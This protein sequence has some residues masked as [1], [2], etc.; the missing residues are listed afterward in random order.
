MLRAYARRLL[1][2][3]GD[4]PRY[5]DLFKPADV[6]TADEVKESIFTKLEQMGGEE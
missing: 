5:I 6:R 1:D 3:Q 4:I 2:I